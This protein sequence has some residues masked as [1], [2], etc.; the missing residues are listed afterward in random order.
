MKEVG[1][2]AAANKA[3]SDDYDEAAKKE[4]LLKPHGQDAPVLMGELMPLVEFA[5][6]MLPLCSGP[7]SATYRISNVR[8]IL[9]V[10]GGVELNM[11]KL[12]FM[13]VRRPQTIKITA[14]QIETSHHPFFK[15]I[16][17]AV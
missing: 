17:F 14:D 13:L 12:Q 11:G 8:R 2:Q 7:D 1:G 5:D 16:Y 10:F 4:R 3:W 6:D 9:M 15:K